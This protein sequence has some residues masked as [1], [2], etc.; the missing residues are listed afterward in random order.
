LNERLGVSRVTSAV[1]EVAWWGSGLTLLALGL[2]AVIRP[3]ADRDPPTQGISSRP[4]TE[5]D[6]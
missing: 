6:H 1:T 5:E 3:G 2:A 4:G